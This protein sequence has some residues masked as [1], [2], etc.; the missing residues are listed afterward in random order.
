MAAPIASILTGK[1]GRALF[2]NVPRDPH[3]AP[4]RNRS[5]VYNQQ[6]NGTSIMPNR[7]TRR[8]Q[9]RSQKGRAC[10]VSTNWSNPMNRTLTAAVALAAGLGMVGLAQAQT[11]SSPMTTAPSASQ[12]GMSGAQNPQTMSAPGQTST[13][14]QQGPQANAQSN[15]QQ[16]TQQASQSQIQEAQQQLKSQGLYRGAV[17]GIMGPETQTAVMAFQ[18]QQG[19]PQ[20]AQLD[21]QTLSRLSGS[22]S[23][24]SNTGTQNMTPSYPAGTQ[25][26]GGATPG[27][28][29]NR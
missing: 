25:N 3:S 15:Q 4:R 5:S 10:P 9:V 26:P 24:Q 21:Q 6:V 20:T 19:L 7:G 27:G 11:S 1:D 14:G 18:R 8:P 22:N 23:D 16:G 2:T 29:N 17:D 12:P 28:T 13:Y